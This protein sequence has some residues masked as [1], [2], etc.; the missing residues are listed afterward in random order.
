MIREFFEKLLQPPSAPAGAL[1]PAGGVDACEEIVRVAR[2]SR[3]PLRTQIVYL[4]ICIFCIRA[5]AP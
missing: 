2:G 1:G 3:A 4:C 5:R